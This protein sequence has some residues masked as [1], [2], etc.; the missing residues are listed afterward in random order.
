MSAAAMSALTPSSSP[1]NRNSPLSRG[2]TE[3]P[4]PAAAVRGRMTRVSSTCSRVTVSLKSRMKMGSCARSTGARSTSPKR[5]TS[6]SIRVVSSSAARSCA[7]VKRVFGV[8]T[9]AV[10]APAVL[11]PASIV[12]TSPWVTSASSGKVRTAAKLFSSKSVRVT[13]PIGSQAAMISARR[14]SSTPGAATRKR[15]APTASTRVPSAGSS[16]NASRTSSAATVSTKSTVS[17]MSEARSKPKGVSGPKASA[18]RASRSS[19]TNSV[20]MKKVV[21]FRAWTEAS[22]WSISARRARTSSRSTGSSNWTV[23]EVPL[24]NSR[25]KGNR[26]GMSSA[27]RHTATMAAVNMKARRRLATNSYTLRSVLPL[28]LAWFQVS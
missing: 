1:C 10:T 26:G 18:R 17:A 7:A 21:S 12:S 27:A 19:S 22:P 13:V 6:V 3:T 20:R 9:T 11:R 23:S 14:S 28:C 25:P 5:P 16:P 2:E 24:E 15:S 4:S 8:S